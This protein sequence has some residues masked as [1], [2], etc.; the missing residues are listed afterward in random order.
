MTGAA[1]AV[2]HSAK[3]T[4]ALI[5]RRHTNKQY[6]APYAGDDEDEQD[7]RHQ[8][9]HESVAGPVSSAY[10]PN[11]G[12][13]MR[14]QTP[15]TEAN[16]IFGDNLR[17]LSEC[18]IHV[19]TDHLTEMAFGKERPNCQEAWD[20][21]MRGVSGPIPWPTVWS[22]VGNP[23][24]D[25]TEEYAWWKLV[26]RGWRARDRFPGKT[27]ACRLGCGRLNT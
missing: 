1:L 27:H 23:L 21:R 19:I 20:T 18:T 24:C 3:T 2:P 11:E 7:P 9:I 5:W 16:N 17:R 4:F 22:S 6:I 15:R 25:P 14:G 10:P 8:R 13:Y 26:Q 12:W